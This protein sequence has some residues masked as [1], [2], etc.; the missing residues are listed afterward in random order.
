MVD[1]ARIEVRS[2]RLY[3]MATQMSQNC[4]MEFLP[5]ISQLILHIQINVDNDN[6]DDT[7][8]LYLNLKEKILHT[9]ERE[10]E[11]SSL[12]ISV[13]GSV[14]LEN[15]IL[16]I[17]QLNNFPQINRIDNVL[18]LQFR[19]VQLFDKD[20]V[21]TSSLSKLQSAQS[22]QGNCQEFACSNCSLTLKTFDTDAS[23]TFKDLPNEHWLELL[24]CWSCHDNEFAPIAERVLGQKVNNCHSHHSGHVHE[25]NDI[26]ITN[27]DINGSRAQSY[28]EMNNTTQGLIFPSP[29]R[30]YLGTSFLLMNVADFSLE[31][32]PSCDFILSEKLHDSHYK[33]YRDAISFKCKDF[34]YQESFIKILMHQI[35]DTIDNHSTF[36]FILKSSDSEDK[37]IY[38]R[39]INWNVRIYDFESKS[40]RF[41]IKLGYLNEATSRVDAETIICTPSQFKQ[42][43]LLLSNAHKYILFNSSLKFPGSDSILK[44]SYLI[45]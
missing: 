36:H 32:C 22:L 28:Q 15:L 39:P 10:G 18:I 11:G 38:L 19:H 37:I 9:N 13:P 7:S 42:T 34:Q 2:P 16:P 27:N 35:L 44:L 29:N 25:D 21:L 3:L 6:T 17:D 40:W 31:K 12:L 5:N 24:D 43:D 30:I 33:L 45:N 41:A 23:F 14:Q 1:E 8:K 26:N 20:L 4:S